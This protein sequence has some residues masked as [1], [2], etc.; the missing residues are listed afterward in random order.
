VVLPRPERLSRRRGYG[1]RGPGTAA[2]GGDMAGR[3]FKSS[4]ERTTLR[5]S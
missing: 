3:W 1:D 5:R 2:P 4:R